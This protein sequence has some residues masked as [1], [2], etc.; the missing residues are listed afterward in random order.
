MNGRK[1]FLLAA[2]LLIS[3][4]LFASGA[5]SNQQKIYSIDSPVYEAM[6]RL[7]ISTGYALPSTSGP[8]S[9][10][11][12]SLMLERI[13]VTELDENE[14][15]IYRYISSALTETPRFN[16]SSMF[17]FGLGAEINLE[18]YGHTNPTDYSSPDEYALKSGSFFGDY[19]TPT[20]LLSVPFETWIGPSVYGYMSLDLGTVR[21]AHSITEPITDD[22]GNI[23]GYD[24]RGKPFFHNLIFVAPLAFSDFNMNFPYRA[25]GSF[26]G[27]WWNV[28]I[29]RDRMSW[30]PGVTGNFVIGSQVPYHNNARVSFFTDSFKYIFSMSTFIHPMN[31]M[32]KLDGDDM[33][34]YYPEYSQFAPREGLEMLIAHRLEWRIFNKVNMV[35]TEAIMYQNENGNLDLLVLSPTAIFHNFYIRGNANSILSLEAD[36]AIAEHW[37]LYGQLALDELLMAGEYTAEGTSPSALGYMIGTKYS[38]PTETGVLYGSIEAAYTDPYLYLRDEGSDYTSD[39]YGTDFIVAFPEFVSDDKAAKKLSSYYMQPV[40]YRFGGDAIVANIEAG[41]ESFDSWYAEGNVMYMVHGTF[42]ALTRWTKVTPDSADN[43][44]TPSHTPPSTGSYEKT[45]NKKNSPSHLLMLTVEGG[46]E[47]IDNLT[48]Y[49]RGDAVFIWNKGN[50]KGEFSPDFQFTVGVRYKI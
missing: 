40:G 42:D 10:A 21:N 15:K 33:W 11:E 23:I 8:W 37:N 4:L 31:Y 20:P 26:G 7:Y 3:S 25:F 19:N 5:D 2:L 43:P 46:L 30:G 48:L 41:F 35:L 24:Y 36:F 32:K 50:I 18:L 49:G 1:G 38:Y 12:L 28:S 47:P 9:G 17:G 22:N 44:S 29:G 39:K 45:E 16:P 27:D 13:P 14:L 6:T 34:Y